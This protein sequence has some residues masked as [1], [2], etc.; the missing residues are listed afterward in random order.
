[1]TRFTG[2]LG[3]IAILAVLSC[4]P[5]IGDIKLRIIAGV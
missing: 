2:L 5:P 1:M 3:I 4:C